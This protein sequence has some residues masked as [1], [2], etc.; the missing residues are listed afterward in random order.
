M[1]RWN[2]VTC[3]H[4]SAEKDCFFANWLRHC[5]PRAGR[6]ET[7]PAGC[8]ASGEND[9]KEAVR[10]Y[11]LSAA[12]FFVFIVPVG[13]LS[14]S[15]VTCG[16]RNGLTMLFIAER[17]QGRW[18]CRRGT[19]GAEP[20]AS[21]P[22]ATCGKKNGKADFCIAERVQG[23]CPWFRGYGGRGAP[24]FVVP[25]ATCGKMFGKANLFIAERVQGRWL[26]C[27]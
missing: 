4:T 25:Q 1:S 16:N 23:Q 11:I 10:E 12:L 24:C 20:P 14:V 26:C 6:C 21:F 9:K 22:Q 15:Q 19:G 18:P 27:E 2:S 17:V 3:T 13:S 5:R 7:P 8:F